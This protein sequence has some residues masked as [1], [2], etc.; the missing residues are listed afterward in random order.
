MT[1]WAYRILVILLLGYACFKLYQIERYQPSTASIERHLE[2]VE[3]Q[4]GYLIRAVQGR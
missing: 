4:L 3:Q 2:L 1:L